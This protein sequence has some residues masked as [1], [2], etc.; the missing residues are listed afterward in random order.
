M[1]WFHQLCQVAGGVGAVL[2]LIDADRRYRRDHGVMAVLSAK[3]FAVL[4]A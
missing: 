1:S 2:E 3:V 4:R